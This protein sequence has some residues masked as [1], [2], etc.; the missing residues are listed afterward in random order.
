MSDESTPM[1]RQYR[2]M[3]S[4]LP[5]DV[6]LFFRLGDFYEMFFDDAKKAAGVLD[7]ALTKR[8]GMP[9][10]GIPY[11]NLQPYLAKLVRAGMK[12]A[13]CEQ[14]EDPAA[15]KGIVR[16]EVV[17]VVTPG[18]VIEENVLESGR[19]NFLGALFTHGKA[20]GA[21]ALDLS[22]GDFWVE[23]AATP[24]E[25]VAA[26]LRADPA[27]VI[28][29]ANLEAD[30]PL[31]IALAAQPGVRLTSYEEWT[32]EPDNARDLLLRH[33]KVHSLE[34]YGCA[35]MSAA[36][37]AAGAILHYVNQQL[38]NPV[39]HI[40]RLGVRN[41]ADHMWL[42]EATAANLELVEP[43]N[44][45]ARGPAPTLLKLL[46]ATRTAMGA[47]LLRDWIQRP[48]TDLPRI[49][50]RH[51]A[52]AALIAHR[53]ALAALR[54]KLGEVRDL[55]RTVTRIHSG[56]ANARD[57]VSLAVSLEALP[58]LRD[59]A[60]GVPDASLARLGAEIQTMPELAA[61][62]R[63]ALVDEPP[64]NVRE[65]GMIRPGF[66]AELDGLREAA[67]TGRQWLADYQAA[68]Q[69]RTGIKSLKVR[70]NKIFGYYIEITSSNLGNVPADYQRKQTLVNAERFITPE[71]KDYENRILG[72]QERSVQLEY[73]LFGELRL[74]A[75]EHSA[76]VQRTAAALA[77]L[78]VLG[79]F[80]DRA[81][82]LRYVRPE[83]NDGTRL[84]IKD[85]RHPVIER[86]NEFERFVPNDCFLDTATEQLHIITG[87]NMAGKSTYIRQVALIV[88]MA[89][90]GSFVPAGS[91]E[92]GVVDRVFTRVGASDDL[93][94]G[95]S[96]FMVEMQETA[97]ILNNATPR[98]LIVLDEIGRG[99]STF[100]GISIAWAVAEHLH[101]TPG[102]K[103][104]TLFATHYH[105]LTDLTRTLAGVKNYSVLVRDTKDRIA[106]LRK[107]VPGPAE[108][109]FGI[110]V[111]RLAGL[112]QPVVDRA[113]EI[114]ANL[115]EGEFDKAGLPQIARQRVRK[116]TS[117]PDQ[118]MLFGE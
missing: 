15:A 116:A 93:A 95:R 64:A 65:G 13:I 76:G 98:S 83:M 36:V 5:D 43:R 72:A 57:L 33:F 25:A 92:I 85:G 22:T 67:A 35:G 90:T 115:E 53:P 11:H 102:V 118:M 112:P 30:H 78:D 91:A 60:A 54:E 2:Q 7:I 62:L 109:S 101:N 10:C 41:A 71:L 56:G 16:R 23:E 4:T 34:G 80:A 84:V 50:A 44:A 79:S 66:H 9:M 63:T 99:T 17:R 68:Q 1:M 20:T 110:Q 49:Q 77:E 51:G 39:D 86:L 96:T 31:K 103:A 75:A 21:A 48:L 40:R 100:D 52:V 32:F 58:A 104:K 111:A 108:K 55:E 19:N 74:R 28:V 81:L 73:E 70:H 38:R 27:E 114:L 46:D 117:S 82:D 69:E 107:I 24:D 47:R 42:D 113:K 8:N 26:L 88:I 94:R 37:G 106:F 12:V 87:P 29:P 6:I 97:N 61:H 14:M 89:H 59:T 45:S 3:R 18:T 105:E